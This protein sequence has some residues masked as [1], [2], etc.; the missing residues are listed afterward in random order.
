MVEVAEI[1]TE[2]GGRLHVGLPKTRASQR[3]IGPPRFV[4]RELEAHRA[5]STDPASYIG[6]LHP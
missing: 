4:V 5:G 3:T 1:I 6:Q 2:V